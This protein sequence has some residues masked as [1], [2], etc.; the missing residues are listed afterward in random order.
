MKL[1]A[2]IQDQRAELAALSCICCVHFNY[3]RN[4][5]PYFIHLARA[6]TVSEQI[7]GEGAMTTI[8]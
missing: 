7:V 8:G 5:H 2:N 1:I 4:E 6:W 3:I